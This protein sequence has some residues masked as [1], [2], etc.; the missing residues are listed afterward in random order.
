MIK[1]LFILLPYYI[2]ALNMPIKPLDK[3]ILSFCIRWENR[4]TRIKIATLGILLF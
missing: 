1:S 3:D 2:S 4:N